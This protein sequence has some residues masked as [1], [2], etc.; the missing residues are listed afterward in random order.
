MHE[1][2]PVSLS[3]LAALLER[4]LRTGPGPPAGAVAGGLVAAAAA[5]TQ[6][7]AR[8]SAPAW[9]DAGGVA[10]QAAALRT[11]ALR[12]AEEDV[13]ALRA[14]RAALLS[15]TDDEELARTL[16]RAADCPLAIAAAAAD[17]AGLA[18]IVAERGE[19]DARADAAAAAALA[20]GAATAAVH[21]V[22]VNLATLP[23]DDRLARAR[24]PAATAVEARD[25]AARGSS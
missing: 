4:A 12:L 21:L 20:A 16:A 5:V 2:P 3:P 7:G 14:A 23:D 18:A 6:A 17:V 24:G 9:Q 19:A 8:R 15:R 1:D 10:A 11:R 13:D 25:R 22:E